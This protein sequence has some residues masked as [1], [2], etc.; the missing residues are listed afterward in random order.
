MDAKDKAQELIEKIRNIN[1]DV[2]LFQRAVENGSGI[3]SRRYVILDSAQ[4]FLDDAIC[5]LEDFVENT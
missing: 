2:F 5:E 1:H 3:S 4:L